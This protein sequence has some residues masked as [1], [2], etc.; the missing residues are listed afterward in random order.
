[1]SSTCSNP[2]V[3]MMATFSPLRVSFAITELL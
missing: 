3:T 1:V 2:S